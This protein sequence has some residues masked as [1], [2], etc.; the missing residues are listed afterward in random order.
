MKQRI[1]IGG[2]CLALTMSLVGCGG[3]TAQEPQEPQ[4]PKQEVQQAEPVSMETLSSPIKSEAEAA[5]EDMNP[6][7]VHEEEAADEAVDEAADESA[8]DPF[9]EANETVYATGTVNIRAS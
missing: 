8:A 9:T 6:V 5:P 4:E 2:V 3:Q 7:E 1:I